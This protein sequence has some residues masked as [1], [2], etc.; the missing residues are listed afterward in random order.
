MSTPADLPAIEAIAK[1]YADFVPVAE[2]I[3]SPIY[4]RLCADVAG[5]ELACAFLARLPE[6]KQQPNLFLSAVR[7]TAGLPADRAALE[8]VLAAEGEAIAGLM[9][10]RRTQTNEP[11][12]CATILPALAQIEGPIALIEVGT[13][14]GLCLLP[15]FYGY[16]WG[17]HTLPGE[18]VMHCTANAAT[19]LPEAKPEIVWRAG[20]DLSPIDIDDDGAVAWLRALIWPGLEERV[21]RLDACLEL[22]RR[23]RP[24]I[25]QG[26]LTRDLPALAAEAPKDATLVVIHT[27]VLIYVDAEGRRRFAETLRTIGA[28]WIAAETPAMFEGLVTGIPDAPDASSFLLAVDGRAMGWVHPHGARIDWFGPRTLPATAAR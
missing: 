26:D 3:G 18:P 21:A 28:R 13:A 15:D 1:R 10:S 2:E 6:P 25:R 14:A 9:M 24:L 11:R 22:A 16:D 7:V 20:L 5:S 17:G 12:R 27:A 4:A 19:P 8:E 23:H